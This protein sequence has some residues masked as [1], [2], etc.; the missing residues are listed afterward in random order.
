MSI[1]A[2]LKG[3]TPKFYI[4]GEACK[5]NL[6]YVEAGLAT[7]I[8]PI[9]RQVGFEQRPGQGYLVSEVIGALNTPSILITR[10]QQYE[11]IFLHK[12]TKSPILHLKPEREYGYVL[13]YL[14]VRVSKLGHIGKA[15]THESYIGYD[16]NNPVYLFADYDEIDFPEENIPKL[17]QN[18]PG[19][20]YVSTRKKN[21]SLYEGAKA[22]IISEN[23]FKHSKNSVSNL[24][25]TLAEDGASF[26]DKIYPTEKQTAGD[27]FGC[28]ETF[29]AVFSFTHFYTD[30]FEYSIKQANRAAAQ[31]AKHRSIPALDKEYYRQLGKEILEYSVSK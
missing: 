2:K 26:N 20:V 30:D 4:I 13:N 25:V 7:S 1:K 28:R 24:I 3:I 19:P 31:V 8:F 18:A 15:F 23:D 27:N 12:K 14:D 5:I 22:V 17:I 16:L 10:Q 29:F 21:L 11:T 9:V 6:A